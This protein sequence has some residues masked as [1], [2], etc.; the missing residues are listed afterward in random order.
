MVWIDNQWLQPLPPFKS[1]EDSSSVSL[2]YSGSRQ[3]TFSRP[4]TLNLRFVKFSSHARTYVLS[5][6]VPDLP[7]NCRRGTTLH[8][9]WETKNS[10]TDGYRGLMTVVRGV[11]SHWRTLFHDLNIIELKGGV[12]TVREYRSYNCKENYSS[13]Q[14]QSRPTVLFYCVQTTELMKG[15]PE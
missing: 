10:F 9:P 15:S 2:R 1:P 6:R 5:P 8:V 7:R 3:T 4:P 11:S 14:N 12:Q 13:S